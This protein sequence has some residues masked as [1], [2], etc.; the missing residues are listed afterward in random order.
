MFINKNYTHEEVRTQKQ[1]IY[2]ASRKMFFF[3]GLIDKSSATYT[4]FDCK[5]TTLFSFIQH[6]ALSFSLK[7]HKSLLGVTLFKIIGVR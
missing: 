4:F 5:D 3:S 1:T 2:N 6:F 7:K